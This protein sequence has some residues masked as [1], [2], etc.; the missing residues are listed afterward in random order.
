MAKLML[1]TVQFGLDYGVNN[2]S[3]RVPKKEVFDI[4]NTAAKNDV[5]DL[6]T[7]VAYGQSEQV[8]GDFLKSNKNNFNIVSKLPL[9]DSSQ[10][11][12]HVFGSLN[13]LGLKKIY[14]YLFHDFNHFQKD[15]K[16]LDELLLLKNE[17]Y[18]CKVGFSLYFPRE[19]EWLLN[20]N[21]PFDI[22]QVPFSVFDQRFSRLF[23][24]L[25][26]RGVQIHTRSVFLQGLVF[27]KEDDLQDRFLKLKPKIKKL[28]N[29]AEFRQISVADVCLSFALLNEY[30][31]KVI[32]GVDCKSHFEDN[33]NSLKKFFSEKYDLNDFYGLQENDEKVILPIN[34]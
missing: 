21:V 18:I 20:N 3:G 19:L 25:K 31:D 11:S 33:L 28:N 1:G 34:W 17:D 30:V 15:P 24:L 10:V 23:P 26:N 9:C 22:V 2:L 8:I 16:I 27:K 13:R 12:K 5:L 6:D 14:G 32:I 29:L 7:A 4:L